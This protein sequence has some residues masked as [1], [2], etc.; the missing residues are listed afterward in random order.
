MLAV[1][2]GGFLKKNSNR[3]KMVEETLPQMVLILRIALFMKK[4]KNPIN[5]T[6]YKELYL[7]PIVIDLEEE[8]LEKRIGSLSLLTD[9][10]FLL[11]S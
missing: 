9:D 1:L 5:L 2:N 3:G 7:T 11:N 10:F 6:N 4:M 8:N